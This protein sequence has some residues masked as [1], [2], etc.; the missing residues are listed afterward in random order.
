MYAVATAFAVPL[1]N[2]PAAAFA[3]PTTFISGKNPAG[4]KKDPNDTKGTRKDPNFL[5]SLATCKN[6]CESASNSISKTKEECLEECQEVCCSTYEQ[7]TF[8]IVPQ[9]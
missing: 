9:L 6:Q 1:L 7:C 4:K 5:R 8:A 3:E 2:I